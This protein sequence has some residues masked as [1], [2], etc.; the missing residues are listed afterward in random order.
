MNR[1]YVAIIIGL[2][3]GIW[4]GMAYPNQVSAKSRATLG[5]I[6]YLAPHVSTLDALRIRDA[7]N[8][9][10][11]ISTN[12]K[13]L[14][15]AIIKVESDFRIDAKNKRSNDYG[16]MQINKYHV[17]VKKLS[18]KRLL[19]D[20]RYNVKH[21]CRILSWFIGPKR[22]IW[23]AVARYNCGTRR[24]CPQW[25]RVKR[26]VRLVMKYRARLVLYDHRF[27]LIKKST[28]K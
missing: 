10:C 18:I 9:H 15:L 24:S 13:N 1:Y 5:K 28:K 4:S 19:N 7:V 16:L 23:N 12:D 14:V 27:N 6:Y 2:L 20:A 25:K 17:R 22:D 8:Y 11:L 26:Y 21:G 3:I